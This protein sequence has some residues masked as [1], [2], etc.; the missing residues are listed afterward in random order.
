MLTA[1][2]KVHHENP[3]LAAFFSALPVE[4]RSHRELAGVINDEGQGVV[5][6]FAHLV[7]L[8]V[9]NGEISAAQAPHVL[10]LFIACTIG[11]SLFITAIDNT[12]FT[13][14]IEAFTALI[15][16]TLFSEPRRPKKSR[17]KL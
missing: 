5:R 16:G 8:G 14:I 1:S 3:S 9:D 2:I 4:M 13:G 12:Q 11:L 15:A 7:G 10:S 6:L 17:A